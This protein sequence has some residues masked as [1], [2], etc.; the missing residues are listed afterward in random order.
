MV[1]K[2]NIVSVFVLYFKPVFVRC[3]GHGL[4][5]RTVLFHCVSVTG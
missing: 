4:V 1:Q 5:H 2:H 3:L